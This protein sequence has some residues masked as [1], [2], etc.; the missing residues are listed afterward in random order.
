MKRQ[1]TGFADGKYSLVAGHVESGESFKRTMIREAEEEVGVELEESDLETVYVMHRD[2]DD[3]AY[4]DVFFS[5]TDW[6]GQVSNM[7]PEK[8]S[9][10]K[11]VAP[12]ELPEN[13]LGFVAEAIKNQKHESFYSER[14]WEK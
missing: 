3:S 12:S 2:S 9:G 13:T 1:N 8:C 4:V 6:N 5:A 14:G 7:E 10:L 11:W